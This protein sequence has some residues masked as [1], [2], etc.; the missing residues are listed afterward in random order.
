M[1]IPSVVYVLDSKEKSSGTNQTATYNMVP[2]GGLETGTYQV[3]SYHS[4]NQVYNVEANV[5]DQL[6]WDEGAGD[7]NAQLTPGYYSAAELL[8]EL[9]A[10]LDP[11]SGSTFTVT[12]N[13]ISGKITFVIAAG[14]FRFKYLT[15]LTDPARR[16]IGMDAVDGVLAAS[17]IS[18]I[19]IDL[20]LHSSILLLVDVDGSRNIT[21][22]DGSEFS[23]LFPLNCSYQ[24]ELDSLKQQVF[25]QTI[26]IASSVNNIVVSQFTDDGV[27]LVNTPDYE[28]II[29]K[30][31]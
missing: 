27:A 12:Y 30:L 22:H 9:K 8:V 29:Q 6:W 31:F 15:N 14:T 20:T 18:N 26:T 1:S 10:V 4:T 17:Q 24:S 16:L 28:L 7:L 25:S 5:N 21:I 11:V 2:M 23:L 19:P 13:A 3:L